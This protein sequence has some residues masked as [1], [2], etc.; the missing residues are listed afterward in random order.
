MTLETFLS[1]KKPA[2]TEKWFN[3]ILASYPADTSR[4]LKNQ[5][6][7][8]T[9]PV[10]HTIQQGIT[11]ILDELVQGVDLDRVSPFLDNILRVRAVQDFTPSQAVA[12]I[13]SLKDVVREE[14]EG[15]KNLTVSCDEL[16]RLDSRI[17]KLALASFDIFMKCREKL[18]EIRA[19]ELKRMTFR[20]VQRANE[21]G[22]ESDS[23]PASLPEKSNNDNA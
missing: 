4:Y 9:N 8:F 17:D 22:G 13:F 5:K 10:G 3:L 18:Y 23:E 11:H 2:L 6:D 16:H 20:L 21:L 14:I 12:F 15:E 7:R 19:N 1:E